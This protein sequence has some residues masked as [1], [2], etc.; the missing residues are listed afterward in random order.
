MAR[1]V[2]DPDE[3]RSELIACAQKLFYAKG[4]EST[5]VRDIVDEAGVAKGTFYYYFDSK[6]AVLEATVDELTAYS[7]ALMRGIVDDETLSAEIKWV[8]A[9]EMVGNWK[10]A[11]K[12]ELVA[13][14]RMLQRDENALLQEKMRSKAMQMVAPELARII[15]QGVE[16]GVF[17]TKFVDESAEI[18]MAIMMTLSYTIADTML[19]PDNYDNPGDLARRKL[20]AVQT[21]IERV[22]GASP[23]S[24]PLMD[25]TTLN[26]WFEDRQETQREKVL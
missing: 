3:R 20:T 16:E 24:L 2:K 10:T 23:G 19:N 1:I 14:L 7:V 17:E 12:T 25:A 22:L 18:A 26:V 5:S 11:R 6:Q 4:Y 8:R 9:M 15:E 21:A 13:L